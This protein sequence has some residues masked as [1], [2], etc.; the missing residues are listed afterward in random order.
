MIATPI[1][2]ASLGELG[3]LAVT[4]SL[5]AGAFVG[6]KVTVPVLGATG[7]AFARASVGFLVLLP[8]ALRAG[9]DLPRGASQWMMTAFVAQ[10]SVAIPFTLISF[11]E[12]TIDAGEA[13]LLMGTGPFFAMVGAHFAH[14]DDRLSRWRVVGVL[15]GFAG[16]ATLVGAA[17]TA[18]VASD[19]GVAHAAVV[20]ASLC[21]VVSGLLVRN[22][23]V[24]PL[25]LA[26]LTL[27]IATLTLAPF[28]ASVD[29]GE[30]DARIIAAIAF[31]G[32][33]PTGIAYILRFEL[34][35]RIGYATF[36]LGVNLVPVL[37]VAFGFAFLGES[38]DGR[39]LIALS[40]V[41]AGLFVA[42]IGR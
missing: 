4:A 29:T 2:R 6:M 17:Q 8:F 25:S 1:H 15:L 21:Y 32:V 13:A 26:T 5:W 28:G 30:I 31:L 34:I 9:L 37:G 18:K 12:K 7:T 24:A 23:D 41:V 33:F 14:G 20:G 19:I 39:T 42:R 27:A 38:P 36:A 40:L 10:F 11:G 22:I 16:V 3:L 35:R